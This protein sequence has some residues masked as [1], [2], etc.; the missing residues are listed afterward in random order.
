MVLNITLICIAYQFLLASA[1][2][3]T[4]EQVHLSWTETPNEMRITWVTFFP[5]SSYIYYRSI[6]CTDNSTWTV[7]D[8]SYQ[9]FDAG[10]HFYRIE[11]IHTGVLHISKN[12]TYEYYVGSWLGY[13]AVY[14]FSGRTHGPADLES[15]S[16]LLVA[17][18][19]G[20]SP[21]IFTKNLLLKEM[22]VGKFDAILHAGDIAYNLEYTEGMVGDEW[23]NM[24]QP[25]AANLAYMVIPGNHESDQNFTHYR[26]RFT[27][28]VNDENE[29]SGFFYSFDLGMAHY[30]MFSTES[31]LNKHAVGEMNTTI[32]WLRNDLKKANE[33][34][35]NI[36]WVILLTHH[37]LYCSIDWTR[38]NGEK[39]IDC[40]IR[41]IIYRDTL[42]DII[43]GAG[44]DLFL[45][46]HVHNYE[47][48]TP[49]YQNKT[50]ASEFDSLHAHFNARA[51]VYITNGN[52]G[53][54]RGHNDPISITQQVWS[55]YSN[56]EYGYA[57]LVVH[58]AT[59]L[60]YEQFGAASLKVID[61]VWI[62]KDRPRY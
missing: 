14:S 26:N 53:N 12:C 16:V 21:G 9:T 36:P 33:N 55:V 17:D 56:E 18:W 29:G 47:R 60:Y 42:E 20:S 1:G 10:N 46:A 58:N 19:G 57:R 32:N 2:Y 8:S 24:V 31:F 5:I 11:Y 15:T 52:A 34:R 51:P 25:I 7:A 54:I 3:L 40:A 28:P 59:H 44:V 38:K 49:I 22:T 37:N 13:S 62:T 61:Y 30:V 39:H 45:Q 50:V 41:S 43:Y 27:M 23:M 35:E 4:P 6:L 48:N